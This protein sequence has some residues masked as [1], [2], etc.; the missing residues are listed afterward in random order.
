MTLRVLVRVAGKKVADREARIFAISMCCPKRPTGL[1]GSF[2]NS[3]GALRLSLFG[4]VFMY[5]F[6][7]NLLFGS[8]C[9]RSTFSHCARS[10]FFRFLHFYFK[11]LLH[12]TSLLLFKIHLSII[13]SAPHLPCPKA[14]CYPTLELSQKDPCWMFPMPLLDW[15]TTPIGWPSVLSS[16]RHWQHW[17]PLWPCRLPC[18]WRTNC[19]FYPNSASCVGPPMSLIYDSCSVLILHWEK[20]QS[21][22]NL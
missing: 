9:A 5:F 13:Y 22:K 16:Q 21:Q 15:C 14:N 20:G 1:C 6:W 3:L 7:I 2:C 17:Y 11:T 4:L 19:W 12:L 8:H 18:F 10:T